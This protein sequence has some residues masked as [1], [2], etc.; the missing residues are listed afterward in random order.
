M[1]EITDSVKDPVCGTMLE[2]N[3]TERTSEYGGELYYFC[4]AQCQNDF[5]AAP[6]SFIRKVA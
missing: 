2:K 4:S 1:S 5:E 6:A 3:E